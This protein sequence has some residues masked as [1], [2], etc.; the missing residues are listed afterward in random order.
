MYA[1]LVLGTGA[2][3]QNYGDVLLL[4]DGRPPDSQRDGR[5][6]KKCLMDEG[7]KKV[8]GYDFRGQ[9][10]HTLSNL[11]GEHLKTLPV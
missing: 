8:M 6:K 2:K 1:S 11:T 10:R 4:S 3:A 5:G 9:W 7:D